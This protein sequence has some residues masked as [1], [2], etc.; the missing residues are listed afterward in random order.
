MNQVADTRKGDW[1]QT[2]TGQQFWP[3]DPRP[4][5]IDINDIAWSLAHLCRYNG[6]CQM[7]YS[8]AEHSVLVS[9]ILPPEF[10]LCGLLH[11][12]TEAYCA[13]VPRPLKPFLTGY[14]AIEDG[15]WRAVAKRFGLPEVMPREV[16][17]ADN[18]V[19]MAEK[20]VLMGQNFEWRIKATPANVLI[21]GLT[22]H[23][24]SAAFLQRFHELTQ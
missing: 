4:D 2:F 16:H 20:P 10:A 3:L 13:D 8:V 12:A 23:E 21:K 1:M 6:H 24:A 5:D 18:S 9:Q 15:I 7:F 19:L 14:A 22:P 17:E 11:D